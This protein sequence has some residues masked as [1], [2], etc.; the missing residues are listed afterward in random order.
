MKAETS[1][2][3]AKARA[4]L[5]DAEKIAVDRQRRL[6]PAHIALPDHRG[7]RDADCTAHAANRQGGLG[8][9]AVGTGLDDSA[10]DQL[11]LGE[12]SGP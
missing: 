2:Y 12:A 7:E 11:G 10:G 6:H 3:L 8:D 1:D 4:T 5:A 9:V